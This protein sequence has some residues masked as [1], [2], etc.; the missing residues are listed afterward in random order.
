MTGLVGLFGLSFGVALFVTPICRIAAHRFGYVAAPKADRWH[1]RPTPILG[2]VAIAVSVLALAPWAVGARELG[3]LLGC[4][5]TIFVVGLVD[6]IL[7]LKPSTKLVAEIAIA[8]VFVFLGY[9]LHWS[10]SL[11]VDTVLTLVWLV[12]ITNAFNLL[13]NMDGLSAGVGLIAGAALL[14]GLLHGAPS[15][16]VRYLSLLL[17]AVAGF[18]VYNFHPA[19]IFMGDSGSLFLGLNLGALALSNHAAVAGPNVLSIVAAPL[20]MLLVPIFDTALVTVSRVVAGRAPSQGGRDHTSHRLVAM[21]LSERYAVAVLWTLAAF[22]G[23]IGVAVRRLNGDWAGLLGA[24]FVL[25]MVVFAAYLAN[26]KVYEQPDERLLREGAITPFVVNIMYKRRIAEVL[27]DLCLVTIAYYSSYRLRFEG[28]QW[29]LVFDYF[30]RSLPIVVG[31]QMVALFAVG[32][33][34]PVWRYFGLM[35]AVVFAKAVALGTLTTV[36]LIVY[37]YRFENYSRAVFVMYAALLLLLLTGSRASFRLISEFVRRR[38][39]G[40]RLV[41]Y[42]AGD[43]GSLIVRDLV[44]DPQERYRMV[45]FIDDDPQKQRLRVQGYPVLGGHDALA[46]LVEAGAVDAVVISARR[47]DAARVHALE[48]LC[49]TNNVRLSRLHFDLEDLVSRS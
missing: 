7:S 1:A 6:D 12:G 16:E 26:M 35:D 30:L 49:Q 43:A 42:G 14:A 33:Y 38:R 36:G 32:A 28:A 2:G 18:L 40:R 11:T 5:A 23:V 48:A 25:A 34:R 21:G 47:M 24:V 27:L 19:S 46:A 45:G 44:A 10:A 15:P 39:A 9:R 20:L 4:G 13:D 31:V 22:A 17:G 37:L 41:V 3:P 29:S 8:A